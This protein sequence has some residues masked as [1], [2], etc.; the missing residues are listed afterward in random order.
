ML[1]TET[2]R[3]RIEPNLKHEVD[4]IFKELGLTTSQAIVLVGRQVLVNGGLPFNVRV[5]NKETKEAMLD[6]ILER[7]LKN[8]SLSDIKNKFS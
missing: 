4:K 7:N 1:K 5:P 6:V 8:T 3:A 2:V